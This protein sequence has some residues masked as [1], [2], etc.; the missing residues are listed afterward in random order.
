MATVEE[1]TERLETL[2]EAISTGALTVKHGEVLTTF[3]SL[4]EMLKTVKYLENQIATASGTTAARQPRYI[5]QQ[6]DT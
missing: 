6:S 3:R 1:L 4:D 5:R 2:N